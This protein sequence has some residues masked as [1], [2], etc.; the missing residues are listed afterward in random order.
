MK[1]TS[2]VSLHVS[3]R[4]FLGLCNET[5]LTVGRHQKLL[6]YNLLS[7]LRCI[8]FILRCFIISVSFFEVVVN[9][10]AAAAAE[11][12]TFSGFSAIKI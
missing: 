6:G 5:I 1:L 3:F 4:Y 8:A 9:H 11:L 10:L 12:K 7:W 2:Y